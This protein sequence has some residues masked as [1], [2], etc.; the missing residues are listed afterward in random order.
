MKPQLLVPFYTFAEADNTATIQ[1]AVS[2]AEHLGGDVDALLLEP[3]LPTVASPLANMLLDLSAMANDIR[4]KC[5]ARGEDILAGFTTELADREITFRDLQVACTPGGLIDLVSEHARYRDLILCGLG[6]SDPIVRSIA[7]A[8]VFEAGRP[9]ILVPEAHSEVN[10]SH[11]AI[12][13]DASRVAARAIADAHMF[14]DKA[15]RI[16][17]ISALDEKPL[18]PDKPAHRLAAF[19]SRQG[20]QAEVSQVSCKGRPIGE[21]L[22]AHARENGAGLLVMGGFGHSRLREFV[23]GGATTG[24]LDK[25][26]LPV[27]MSH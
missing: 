13:W 9:T 14:L 16:T 18:G 4:A 8:A 11:V 26:I 1:A 25:A 6:G 15:Q 2:V 5:R 23:I 3:D 22:Q 20:R 21:T 24:V 17:I 7:E 12:A 27:L 10:F 19:L